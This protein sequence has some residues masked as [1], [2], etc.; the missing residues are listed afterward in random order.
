MRVLLSIKLLLVASLSVLI[1][2]TQVAYAPHS[3]VPVQTPVVQENLGEQVARHLTNRYADTRANCGKDSQPSFLCSGI[4]LRGTSSNPTYH[5]WNNSPS[6]IAKGGVSFVYLRADTDFNRMPFSYNNGFIFETYFH[7]DGKL[8]PEVLCSF[9]MDAWTDSRDKA[10]CGQYPGYAGSDLCHL[11]G[12]T[13]AAQWWADYNSHA[14]NRNQSQCGFDV[15]DGRNTLAG[16]A[17]MASVLARGTSY[18]G[19]EG[20]GQNNELVVKVWSDNLGKTLP[21]EAFFYLYGTAGLPV[22]QRNQRDLKQTDGVLIPIISVR[23][24]PTQTGIA[25][26]HYIASDQTEPMPIVP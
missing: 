10:G 6:A 14:T 20:Y 4:M 12:I 21:L 26:F 17:F 8:H 2:C 9:P 23:L 15:Q 25:T 19:N 7:A 5:V 16:P 1:S 13:T 11:K 3:P 18:L 24:A 22:A